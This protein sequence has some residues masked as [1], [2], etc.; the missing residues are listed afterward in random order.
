MRWAFSFVLQSYNNRERCIELLAKEC[1]KYQ[2]PVH[3][4]SV[5]TSPLACHSTDDLW[6]RRNCDSN[7]S[8]SSTSSGHSAGTP[9]FG[10][11]SQEFAHPHIRSSQSY[12]YIPPSKVL[13][14]TPRSSLPTASLDTVPSSH[15]TRG[16]DG[17]SPATAAIVEHDPFNFRPHAQL[18][19]DSSS[20]Q[21]AGMLVPDSFGQYSRALLGQNGRVEVGRNPSSCNLP[22][23]SPNALHTSSQNTVTSE[24]R[25]RVSPA[26][27]PGELAGPTYLSTTSFSML[28][29]EVGGSAVGAAAH[30]SQSRLSYT[31]FPTVF[32][33]H[34][35]N[36]FI[37]PQQAWVSSPQMPTTFV[38]SLS[39]SCECLPSVTGASEAA[40]HPSSSSY[41]PVPSASAA[42][43][44]RNRNSPTA[45]SEDVDNPEYVNCT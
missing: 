45:G 24:V 42:S 18:V 26:G 4:M 10:Q 35:S 9:S 17:S 5:V 6:R 43:L 40:V 13:G 29:P 34:S 22:G 11:T 20:A 33:R 23:G 3:N 12:P 19:Q 16:M 28:A 41:I 39:S 27:V 1:Q 44:C 25:Y 2:T 38:T 8:I 21:N 14:H 15:R 32:S 30:E 7:E 31:R 37:N 36:A